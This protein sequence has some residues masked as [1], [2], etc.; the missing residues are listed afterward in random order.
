MQ[1]PQ[2]INQTP[3]S[4]H[5][6][7]TRQLWKPFPFGAPLCVGLAL[8]DPVV[9]AG[10]VLVLPCDVANAPGEYGIVVLAKPTPLGPML[11][12]W[13]LKT[14]VVGVAPGPTVKVLPPITTIDELISVK[15]MPPAVKTCVAAFVGAATVV[16]T[17]PGPA[18]PTVKVWSPKMATVEL[19]KLSSVKVMP[20]AVTTCVE[21][22]LF[23][24]GGRIVVLG[25]PT[26]PGPMLNVWPLTTTVVGVA[27]GPTVNVWVPITT[28]EPISEIV[29]PP[30]VMTWVD[31]PF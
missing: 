3:N 22:C 27:P 16:L 19:G 18:V 20:P 6:A 14:S 10:D 13:E 31:G 11:M 26:P 25:V 23:G 4:I 15:V 24:G 17:R 7:E 5:T 2:N 30:A 29:T 8:G 12:V 28:V 21:A 9:A 1:Y